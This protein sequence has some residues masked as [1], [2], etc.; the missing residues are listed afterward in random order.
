MRVTKGNF[1]VIIL[2]GNWYSLKKSAKGSRDREAAVFVCV[3][4]PA[5]HKNLVIEYEVL[6]LEFPPSVAEEDGFLLT[7]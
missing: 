7:D 2:I 4:M 3:S 5:N 1:Y 6:R